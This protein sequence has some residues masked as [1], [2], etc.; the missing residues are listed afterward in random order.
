MDWKNEMFEYPD[1]AF[2]SLWN[3][4]HKKPEEKFEANPWVWCVTMEVVK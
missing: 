1:L 3:A 2:A 4:T